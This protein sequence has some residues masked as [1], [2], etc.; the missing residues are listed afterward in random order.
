MSESVKPVLIVVA[1]PN[2]SGKTT[3]TEQILRHQWFEGCA[4]INPDNIAQERFGDWDSPEASLKAAQEAEKIR[5]QCLLNRESLAFETVLSMPDKVEYIRRAKEA[6]YFVRLFFIATESPV[7]NAARIASRVIGGGHD[8]PIKK[9]I[10]RYSRSIALSAPAANLA[11]RSYFYDNSID[12]QE[13]TLRFRTVDGAVSKVYLEISGW[14]EAVFDSLHCREDME[15][16]RNAS[17]AR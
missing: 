4:Y 7:I 9:V 14:T 10:S 5:E 17:G 15:D 2:G 11:D 12:L 1:G 16:L 6:G 13:P 3:L 8:V